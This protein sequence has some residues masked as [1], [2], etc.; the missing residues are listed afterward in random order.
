[1]GGALFGLGEFAQALEHFE[2]GTALYDPKKH[3]S[4]AALY[5]YDL[6]ASCLCRAF[7]VLWY[8]GYPDQALKKSEQALTLVQEPF[9]PQ[10]QAYT[11]MFAAVLHQLRREGQAVQK[12]AETAIKLSTEEG[13]PLW[14]ASGNILQG[15]VLSQQGQIEEGI[16]QLLQGLASWR[17]TGAELEL[18]YFLSQLVEA[19][20]KAGREK[21]GLSTLDEA[22]ALVQ[23]NGEHSHEAELFRLK[24]DLLLPRVQEEAEE[25]FRQAIAIARRQSAKSLELRAAMSLSRLWQHQGKQSDAY[26]LLAPVYTWFTEGFGTADL[27]EAKA[28]LVAL[29]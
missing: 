10:S 13:L 29:R 20:G 23:K 28:L 2:E 16:T 8:L 19:Y 25:C 4:F 7:F 24:G 26:E 6:G 9:H 22:I 27:K 14:L 17:A 1:V 12:L 5:G 3:R 18:P 15:W 21:E 11:L